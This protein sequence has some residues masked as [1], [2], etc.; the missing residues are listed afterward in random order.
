MNV[1][2]IASLR[3]QRDLSQSELGE[4][5]GVTRQTI[6]VWERGER[7]PSVGQLA[8]IAKA[9]GVPLDVFFE[10]ASLEPALLF[11]SDDPKA[12]SAAL[13]ALI[14]QQATYYAEI[15][16]ELGEIATLPQDSKLEVYDP[17]QVERL[18]REVRDF[19]GV[20]NAPL[21]DVIA[22]LEDRGLKI[23]LTTLPNQ[24]SGF[25]AYTPS[26]GTV[27]VVNQSHPVERQYFTAL[28]ELAHL[29]CHRADYTSVPSATAHGQREKIANHLAG[30]VLLPREI[31]ERELRTFR[32]RWI[33]EAQ[34]IDL[35]LRFSVSMRTTLMRAEQIG[36]ISKTQLGQQLGILKKQYGDTEPIKLKR[37]FNTLENGDPTH[38][39]AHGR[40][41]RLVYQAVALEHITRSRA[42]EILGKPMREIREQFAAW[43]AT[44][45]QA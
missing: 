39:F 14:I 22:Q 19:L 27:I 17:T 16:R 44:G 8:T 18:A 40:L 37:Q 26:L 29:I 1:Q 3:E 5:I 15:E 10:Q 4:R 6:A 13:R 2:F 42:A 41:E 45:V 34:L 30:A 43:E 7:L 38:R 21:G 35:K 36:I 33:P 24:V 12:L 11:R 28:H 25:S 9:L 32:N 31:I 23:I 20:E